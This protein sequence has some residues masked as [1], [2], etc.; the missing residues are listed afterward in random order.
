MGFEEFFFMDTKLS[1]LVDPE[2]ET[3]MEDQDSTDAQLP[4]I[5]REDDGAAETRTNS[6]A[7][8]QRV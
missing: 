3:G 5:E 8:F 2:R 6:R 7:V 4:V 1:L